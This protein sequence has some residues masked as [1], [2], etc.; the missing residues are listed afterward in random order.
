MFPYN[1]NS[2]F[3]QTHQIDK[4]DPCSWYVQNVYIREMKERQNEAWYMDLG[5]LCNCVA[6]FTSVQTS[7]KS[8]AR[9]K[10]DESRACAEGSQVLSR[11]MQNKWL[12]VK[13]TIVWYS[14]D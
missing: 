13:K 10:D 9:I 11:H 8:S 2:N 1:I 4:A 14:N 3:G 12:K 6:K 5:S 7:V